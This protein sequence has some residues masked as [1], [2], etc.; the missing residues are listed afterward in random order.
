ME[1]MIPNIIMAFAPDVDLIQIEVIAINPVHMV[2]QSH[3]ESHI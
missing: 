1:Q 3:M 2:L